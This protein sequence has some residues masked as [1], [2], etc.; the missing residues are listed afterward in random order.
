[1]PF[2]KSVLGAAAPLV[3]AAPLESPADDTICV[4]LAEKKP[5]KESDKPLDTE[6]R[7]ESTKGAI[8]IR[9]NCYLL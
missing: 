6:A 9:C 4:T 1:M 8:K 2:L 5:A 7:D 3:D